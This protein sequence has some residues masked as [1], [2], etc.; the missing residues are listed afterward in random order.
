MATLEADTAADPDQLTDAL[1]AGPGQW[2]RTDHDG[3]IVE[4]VIAGEDGV[5]TT[6]KLVV[7][8][9]IIEKTAVRLDRKRD[10]SN[11]GTDR[12][13]DIEAARE[14]VE[15]ELSTVLDGLDASQ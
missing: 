1:P 4:Y 13:D 14:T 10:C 8:P 5:C 11:A 3:G 2:D 12:F 9:D 6:A 7:R 15:R